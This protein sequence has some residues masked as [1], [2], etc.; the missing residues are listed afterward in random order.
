[1]KKK[2]IGIDQIHRV[3]ADDVGDNP[4]LNR[5]VPIKRVIV[6]PDG[7][8]EFNPDSEKFI[9]FS[10]SYDHHNYYIFSKVLK[11]IREELAKANADPKFASL[12]LPDD[13]RAFSYYNN[14]NVDIIKRVKDFFRNYLPPKYVELVTL[15]YLHSFTD[16]ITN[17]TELNVRKDKTKCGDC[18]EVSDKSLHGG[19]FGINNYWLELLKCCT[20]SSKSCELSMDQFFDFLLDNSSR[21]RVDKQRLNDVLSS[22]HILMQLLNTLTYKELQNPRFF[23][24]NNVNDVIKYLQ[25]IEDYRLFNAKKFGTSSPITH[26]VKRT[27]KRDVREVQDHPEFYVPGKF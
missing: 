6:A 4:F 13:F 14:V 3:Q 25:L 20:I 12:N 10:K 9:Y 24:K 22:N 19:A 1:M 17:C 2:L 7:D 16:L 26:D 18:P 8:L 15:K 23:D 5:S 21:V 11:I 27:F